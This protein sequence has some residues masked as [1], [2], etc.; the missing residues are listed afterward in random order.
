M[1]AAPALTL[2]LAFALASSSPGWAQNAPAVAPPTQGTTTA[3]PA[4]T[5]PLTPATPAPSATSAAL[6]SGEP[7]VKR[8]VIEDEGTRIEELRVRG[9]PQR[10]V[11]TPKGGGKLPYE[12]ITGD[13]SR[14][15]SP[16]AN[17]SRGA[18]GKRVWNVLSF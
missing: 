7:N 12:I 11:V 18:A 16:G 9:Q 1:N 2:A 14:D 8:T 13:G 5:L 15:L 4:N 6:P 10:I 17:T 3:A